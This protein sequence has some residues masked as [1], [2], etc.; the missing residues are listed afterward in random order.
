[1]NNEKL[2][3]LL[4]LL[5]AAGVT[6]SDFRSMYHALSSV[7]TFELDERY[8]AI[9]ASIRRLY[10]APTERESLTGATSIVMRVREDV[11]DFA[12][13]NSSSPKDAA[14][15]LRHRLRMTVEITGTLPSFSP[16]EGFGRWLERV[17][18]IISPNDVL[19]AAIAEFSDTA[20]G[21][22]TG[23]GLSDT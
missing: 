7:S 4:T 1:M 8:G 11:M 20:S 23:W 19:N 5:A 21:R 6:P 2:D 17:M 9:R 22:S 15:R 13:Q 14:E 12:R 16:K 3:R 18:K 10:S